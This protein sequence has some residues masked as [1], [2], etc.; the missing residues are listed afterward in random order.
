MVTQHNRP[1]LLKNALNIWNNTIFKWTNRSYFLK[2]YHNIN[3]PDEILVN[4][5]LDISQ[6]GPATEETF[7]KGHNLGHFINNMNSEQQYQQ[8]QHYLKHPRTLQSMLSEPKKD[9]LLFHMRREASMDLLRKFQEN[10]HVPKIFSKL[11]S[12]H[13]VLSIGSHGNGLPPHM[14]QTSWLGLI[15]G[16]KKWYFFPPKSLTPLKL[17]Q[18]FK[19]NNKDGDAIDWYTQIV[20]NT[21]DT[22]SPFIHKTLID[23][24][25]MLEC[26]QNEGD[27]IWFPDMWIHATSNIGDAIAIGAQSNDEKKMIMPIEKIAW[28]NEPLNLFS[29]THWASKQLNSGIVSIQNAKQRKKKSK[30]KRD[31]LFVYIL[32]C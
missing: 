12:K 14:H 19:N 2:Q 9:P 15:V 23:N 24:K 3:L 28:E 1:I 17:K 8:Q 5:T 11:N 26:V 29:I 16:Q 13:R 7:T 18:M 4:K 32:K 6:D 20:L 30:K 10:T 22:Y 25:V 27:V 21:P 31:Y